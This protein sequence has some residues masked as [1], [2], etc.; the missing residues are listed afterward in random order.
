[1]ESIMHLFFMKNL[2]MEQLIHS[3]YFCTTF[4][5]NIAQYL[6][7]TLSE[8]GQTKLLLNCNISELS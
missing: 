8:R 6:E 7:C 1:M 4:K 5:A 3:N 2:I